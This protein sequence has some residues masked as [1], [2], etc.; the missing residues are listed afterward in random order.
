MTFVVQ[1]IFAGTENK[2]LLELEQALKLFKYLPYLYKK[3]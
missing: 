1:F 3:K 2:N